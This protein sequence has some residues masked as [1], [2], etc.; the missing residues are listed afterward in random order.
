M[1]RISLAAMRCPVY[2]PTAHCA[3]SPHRRTSELQGK[4]V[5]LSFTLIIAQFCI[6]IP[7]SL[8]SKRSVSPVTLH[9]K[10]RQVAIRSLPSST[11]R[12]TRISTR[13]PHVLATSSSG[14]LIGRGPM[15]F[16]VRRYASVRHVEI[17]LVDKRAIRT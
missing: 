17:R 8:I 2:L 16:Q 11:G 15:T 12:C 1:R 9:G 7:F 4:R 13:S 3:K 14:A 5:L 6:A 10:A